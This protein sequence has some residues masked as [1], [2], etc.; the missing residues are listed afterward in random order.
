MTGILVFYVLYGNL[1]APQEAGTFAADSIAGKVAGLPSYYGSVFR[2]N[3]PQDF[4]ER[5][6]REMKIDT[7]RYRTDSAYR[8][9][10]NREFLIRYGR[11][12][13]GV[14]AGTGDSDSLA[15]PGDSLKKE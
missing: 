15:V 5:V 1:P 14:F 13:E 7:V 11:F 2:T 10:L 8:V 4:V 6:V 9:Q 12:D 3:K